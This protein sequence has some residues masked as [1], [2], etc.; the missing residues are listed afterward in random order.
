MTKKEKRAISR[1]LFRAELDL[2]MVIF[3]LNMLE[4][5]LKEAGEKSLLLEIQKLKGALRE[6]EGAL[7]L[8]RR[9]AES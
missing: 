7:S 3:K 6:Q 4:A 2:D 8:I 5:D 1:D 9:R